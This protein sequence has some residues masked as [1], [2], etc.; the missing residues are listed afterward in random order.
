MLKILHDMFTGI[1]NQTYDL[2]RFLWALA[3]ICFLIKA[4]LS[5]FNPLEYSGALCAILASGAGA[6]AI[7]SK[8]EPGASN[9]NK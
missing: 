5:P 3:T 4:Q 2:G 8:T 6:I 1:D 7:K 9:G